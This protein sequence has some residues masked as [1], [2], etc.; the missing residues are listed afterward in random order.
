[1]DTIPWGLLKEIIST[2]LDNWN[3]VS[4]DTIP[5]G[6][7]KD[8]DDSGFVYAEKFQWILFLGAY[9]KI[10]AVRKTKRNRFQWILFLGA[11]FQLI[12]LFSYCLRAKMLW[13]SMNNFYFIQIYNFFITSCSPVNIFVCYQFLSRKLLS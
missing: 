7:L 4:V 10:F 5:W 12:H 13:F 8:V 6:L 1:M 3:G 11:C 9:L 2:I